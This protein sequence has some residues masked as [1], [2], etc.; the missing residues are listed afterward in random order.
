MSSSGSQLKG[1]NKRDLHAMAHI[2]LSLSLFF[3]GREA[4]RTTSPPP[5]PEITQLKNF[6]KQILEG[7]RRQSYTWDVKR[8]VAGG[9]RLSQTTRGSLACAQT[10]RHTGVLVFTS[11]TKAAP[12]TEIE[13]TF[14]KPHYD[15]HSAW[16][17]TL[18]M[19][20]LRTEFDGR[21]GSGPKNPCDIW[22]RTMSC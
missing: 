3:C 1:E 12:P 14:K 7:L 19:A 13:A 8:G 5:H 17:T 15:Q 11:T 21:Q 4:M 6:P 2:S 16:A 10:R 9:S 18:K 20:G 22:P